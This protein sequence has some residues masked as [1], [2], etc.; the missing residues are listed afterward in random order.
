MAK[1][2]SYLQYFCALTVMS[3]D[4][5]DVEAPEDEDADEGCA[6]G[7]GAVQIK[8]KCHCLIT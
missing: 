3:G 2:N 7:A 4:S 5:F 1:K 6:T 8:H